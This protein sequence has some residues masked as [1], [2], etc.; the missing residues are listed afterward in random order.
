M[1]EMEPL[2]QEDVSKRAFEGC[3]TAGGNLPQGGFGCSRSREGASTAASRLRRPFGD[4]AILGERRAGSPVSPRLGEALGLR[5]FEASRKHL[6]QTP[7]GPF[8]S[9]FTR[10]PPDRLAGTDE[11]RTRAGGVMDT[12]R[13]G[14]ATGQEQKEKTTENNQENKRRGKR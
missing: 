10:L 11:S 13:R 6:D 7:Q 1:G 14:D 12:A 3:T 4:A 5:R 9:A 2:E 8:V